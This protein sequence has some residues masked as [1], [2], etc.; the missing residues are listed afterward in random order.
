MKLKWNTIVKRNECLYTL[1]KLKMGHNCETKWM[2]I[3]VDE[4]KDVSQLWSEMNVHKHW[5]N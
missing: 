5:W 3:A 1:M 4:I 2:S